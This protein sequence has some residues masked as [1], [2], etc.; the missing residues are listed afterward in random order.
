M[1]TEERLREALQFAIGELGEAEDK[2]WI[3]HCNHEGDLH[4]ANKDSL[5]SAHLIQD[6]EMLKRLSDRMKNA[7]NQIREVMVETK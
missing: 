5:R 7:R 6:K 4:I 3:A 1:T 2:F